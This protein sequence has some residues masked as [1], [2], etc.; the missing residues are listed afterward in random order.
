MTI[1]AKWFLPALLLLTTGCAILQPHKE[2]RNSVSRQI[3]AAE[4]NIKSAKDAGAASY[5]PK[6]LQ[7]AESDLK[8]AKGKSDKKEYDLA[9]T[10]AKSSESFATQALKKCE[11][12]KRRSVGKK[13]KQ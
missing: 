3:T 4:T 12:A 11:E 1:S 10:L 7:Q 2:E 9:L 5:A 6:E 13:P 8:M